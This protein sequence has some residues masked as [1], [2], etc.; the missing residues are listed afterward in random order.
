MGHDPLELDADNAF[1]D[2]LDAGFGIRNRSMTF[3]YPTNSTQFDLL[4]SLVDAKPGD[5]NRNSHF[6]FGFND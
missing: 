5:M 3:T 4:N 1:P 2:P 6:G